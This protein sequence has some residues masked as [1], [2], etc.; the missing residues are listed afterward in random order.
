M[1]R[2]FESDFIFYPKLSVND[3]GNFLADMVIFDKSDSALSEHDFDFYP[4]SVK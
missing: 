3:V 1:L 2:L 4:V